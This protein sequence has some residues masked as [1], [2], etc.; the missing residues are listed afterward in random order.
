MKI[1]RKWLEKFV[2]LNGILNEDI[3]NQLTMRGIEVESF[4]NLSVK[5]NGIV[6]GK[7]LDVARHPNAEKLKICEVDIGNEVKNIICGAPNVATGQYVAVGLVGAIIPHDQHDPE[8]KPF[9]LGKAKIRGVESQGMI[10]SEY[11]LDLG[12]DK[13]GIMVLDENA[14]VGASLAQFLELDDTIFEI[15]ITPNRPDCLSHVGIAREV[16]AAFSRKLQH[17]DHDIHEGTKS[18]TQFATVEVLDHTLCPRYSA[19]VVTGTKVVPSPRWLRSALERVGMRSINNVVDATN[20][21]MLELGQPLHAFDLDRLEGRKIVVRKPHPFETR[22]TTLDGKEREVDSDMLIIA[23]AEKVVAIAGVMGGQNSEINSASTNIFLESANFLPSAI[24]RASKKLGLSSEASYRFERGVDPNLTVLAA[25]LAA[26]IIQE[27]GGGEIASGIIDVKASDFPRKKIGVNVK[28]INQLLGLNLTR[29]EVKQLLESID[30][31]SAEDYG[32]TIQCSIPT[33][34]GDIDREVDIVE[35]VAR[36]Y[37]YEKIPDGLKTELS[38]DSRFREDKHIDEIRDFLS[39]AGFVEIVTN[40]LQPGDPT[41]KSSDLAVQLANPISDEMAAMRTSMLPSTLA[42]VKTNLSHSVLNL[43]LFEIGRIYLVSPFKQ[44]VGTF[45]EVNKLAIALT[46]FADP[47]SFDRPEHPFDIFDLKSEIERL[48]E[49]FKLD[50]WEF[51]SYDSRKEYRQSLKLIVDGKDAGILGQ[52][53]AMQLSEYDIEQDVL[54][55]EIDLDVLASGIK[56]IKRYKSLPKFPYAF[57]DLSF[58]VDANV[59]VGN[60]ISSIRR[61]AGKNFREI[62]LF[63]VYAGEGIPEGKK[64]VAFSVAVGSDDRTLN[65]S[66]ISNFINSVDQQLKEE[67]GAV[68]RKQKT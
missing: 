61:I 32:D 18:V 55:A 57:I 39:G 24:R 56:T 29:Q 9:K 2:N 46:G 20:Y 63:D 19:R 5:Y 59:P 40:S 27:T 17:P 36:L 23:D 42:V 53:S 37:G 6:I 12:N 26:A 22:F 64:S 65:D 8:G 47:I 60:L 50:N 62:N 25:D 21:V 48:F 34:R 11:E 35:E 45:L 13:A 68:L 7:V 58:I 44:I 33:F 16:A 52:V 49:R 41:S 54:F 67:F 30:I 10:C 38:F 4:E 15:S 66:D 14:P 3:A 43:K 28:R 51:I 31:N 1:S